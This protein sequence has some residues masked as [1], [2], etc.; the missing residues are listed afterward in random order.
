MLSCFAGG[1]GATHERLLCGMKHGTCEEHV[2]NKVYGRFNSDMDSFKR[3]VADVLS[4]GL[5]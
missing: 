4:E 5:I 3:D 2:L 1:A